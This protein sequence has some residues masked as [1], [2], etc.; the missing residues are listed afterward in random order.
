MPIFLRVNY[1][2]DVIRKAYRDFVQKTYPKDII[3][4]QAEKGDHPADSDWSNLA[5]GEV[6]VHLVPGATHMDMLEGTGKVVWAKWLNTYLRKAQ[7]K[8][9]GTKI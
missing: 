8:Y 3:L 2:L 4:I 6:T 7:E 9:T 1:A 5:E